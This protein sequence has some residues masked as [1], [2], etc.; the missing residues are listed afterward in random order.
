MDL[1]AAYLR[2]H[3]RIV[4]LVNDDNAEVEVPTCP[5]WTVKDVIGHCADL[6]DVY[7]TDPKGGFS[8]GWGERGVEARRDRPLQGV[9]DEWD[10]L[11]TEP[12]NTFDGP[13]AQTAVSDVLAHEQDIRTALNEPGAGDDE[14][15]VPSVEMGLAW[16]EKKGEGLPTL[17]IVT[18]DIDRQIGDGE[19][20]IT[21]R[22]ST[23]ELFRAIQGRRTFEQVKALAWSGD[24]DPWM[25]DFFLFGPTERVVEGDAA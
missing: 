9:L 21:L 18:E 6:I 8:E 16:L 17:H 3:D 24:P 23:L 22:T 13:M 4:S 19:P 25:K 1:A 12:G 5:G 7:Q 15:I 2:A 20:S 10:A 14:A 11:I